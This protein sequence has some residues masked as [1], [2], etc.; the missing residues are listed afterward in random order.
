MA[1]SD[2]R[3]GISSEQVQWSCRCQSNGV[4]Y[5]FSVL[6]NF[7]DYWSVLYCTASSLSCNNCIGSMWMI[8]SSTELIQSLF[9]LRY[10]NTGS[11]PTRSNTQTSGIKPGKP[12][13]KFVLVPSQQQNSAA[14]YWTSII[15]LN[16][17]TSIS[18]P[19]RDTLGA[20]KRQEQYI[21]NRGPLCFH[22]ANKEQRIATV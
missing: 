18:V 21:R 2:E 17:E 14:L 15:L 4:Q 6:Y 3:N 7:I 9:H 19:S 8:D 20:Y 13:T 10:P 5:Q 22:D 12:T 11:P 1:V 16:W